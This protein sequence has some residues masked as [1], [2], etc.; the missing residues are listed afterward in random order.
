MSATPLRAVRVPDELWHAARAE[1]DREGSTVSD[2]VRDAL[3]AYVAERK[4]SRRT[5]RRAR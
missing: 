3:A 4:E 5:P 2:V 1:A